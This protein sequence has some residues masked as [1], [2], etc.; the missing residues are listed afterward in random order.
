MRAAGAVNRG[1]GAQ[2]WV[3]LCS[4][5]VEAVKAKR[6]YVAAPSGGYGGSYPAVDRP[7]DELPP[8]ED[9]FE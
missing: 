3:Y 9:L 4:A 6:L 2:G 5:C 7:D 1:W 8:G